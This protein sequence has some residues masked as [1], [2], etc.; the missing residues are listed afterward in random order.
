MGKMFHQVLLARGVPTQMVIYPDEG[1]G[2]RQPKHQVDVLQRT[3]A[4]FATHD[5]SAPV[6]VITLGDSITKGVRGGV[7]AEETFAS[8]VQSALREQGIAAEVTNVGIGGE[9]TD[10]ALLRLDKDVIAKRPRIVT[11]MYGTND[12]YVDQGQSESRLTEHEY[13][14]NLV[15][16]V[17]RLRRS[18]IQPV[19]MTEPRWSA[20]ATTNGVG[21]HPN[22]RLAKYHERCR[23]VAQELNVPLI[24]HFAHWTE[25]EK[26]GQDLRAW[27]TD[28]CHPNPAGHEQLADLITLEIVKIVVEPSNA[29][30]ATPLRAH[31]P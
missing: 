31:L 10:Q 28:T 17:E 8:R 22:L 27:T 23:D 21:E 4:W 29:G 3:L 14:D 20:A 13:R 12:S 5:T 7:T 9:R 25:K 1:H 11:I 30:K 26:A 16:V 15:Q 19:L 6:K 2:I 18:G 24:D